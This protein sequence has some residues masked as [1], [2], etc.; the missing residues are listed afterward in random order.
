MSKY[1]HER[2]KPIVGAQIATYFTFKISV[3]HFRFIIIII[4]N[5]SI[6]FSEYL[7]QEEF[8]N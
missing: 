4:N 2:N 7:F 1:F 6:V 8:I 5:I 3:E